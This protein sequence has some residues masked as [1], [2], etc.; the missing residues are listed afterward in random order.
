[1]GS[2]LDLATGVSEQGSWRPGGS[3]DQALDKMDC[4]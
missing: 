4:S 1:M 2:W 3:L